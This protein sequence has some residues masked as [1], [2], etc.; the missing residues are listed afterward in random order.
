VATTRLQLAERRTLSV[1]VTDLQKR[2]REALL[3]GDRATATSI[4]SELMVAREL[5]IELSEAM[6]GLRRAAEAEAAENA[7]VSFAQDYAAR[8]RAAHSDR[9]AVHLMRAEL[10]KHGIDTRSGDPALPSPQFMRMLMSDLIVEAVGDVTPWYVR[11]A[12]G[13]KRWC[14]EHAP[15]Y[16]VWRLGDH[17]RELG[18]A[19]V[20]ARG[21]IRPLP[22]TGP[23][24]TAT[25]G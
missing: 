1:E 22:L 19:L 9:N 3:G 7:R 17:D 4:T 2:R 12:E 13:L 25:G 8:E 6:E 14:A 23:S 11:D 16:R 15:R 5:R 18:M 20:N 10:L 21:V 24:Y